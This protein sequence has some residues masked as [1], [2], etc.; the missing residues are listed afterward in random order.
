[1]IM[2]NREIL[3]HIK[4]GTKEVLY[5]PYKEGGSPLPLRPLSSFELDDC[6]YRALKEAPNKVAAF[7]VDLKLD[8][9]RG[10][11]DVKFSNKTYAELR[12]Y[13]DL[14]DYWVV[15]HAMKDF[16]DEW[17]RQPNFETDIPKGFEKVKEMQEIHKIASFVY[18]TSF[19]PKEV[20]EK[21]FSDESGREIAYCVF[22]LKVPLCEISDLTRLQRSYLLYAK[23]KLPQIMDAKFKE[24]S[25]SISG[26][27]MSWQEFLEK[28]GL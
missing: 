1:M 19:Q 2:E 26:E 3:K 7:L 25:Y 14:I 13:Y 17:F 18:D 28:F 12:K 16:Q 27:E 15:Y 23:G 10:E 22:Y 11:Q 21:I 24:K 4:L 9:I 20:I 8:L 5:Y 6:F